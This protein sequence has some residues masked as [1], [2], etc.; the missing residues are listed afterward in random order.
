[1]IASRGDGQGKAG[2]H[3]V[4][5]VPLKDEGPVAF[6]KTLIVLPLE[7]RDHAVHSFV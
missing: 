3:I 2:Y 5:V 1:M 4:G 7:F 6:S